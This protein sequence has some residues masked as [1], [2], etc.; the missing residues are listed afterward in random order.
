[1]LENKIRVA[2]VFNIIPKEFWG[3][4]V[5]NG[6]A[7]DMRYKDPESLIVGLKYKKVRTK[8][9]NNVKFVIQ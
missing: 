4:T 5:I 8:I 2:V 1:M 6:D 9:S 3:H 7:Y